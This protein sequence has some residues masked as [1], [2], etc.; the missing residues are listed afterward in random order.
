MTQVRRNLMTTFGWMRVAASM[1]AA[2][3]A[4]CG[5]DDGADAAADWDGLE[6]ALVA[7][8]P[9]GPTGGVRTHGGGR[10]SADK[11]DRGGACPAPPPGASPD[12]I[13]AKPDTRG[14][15]ACERLPDP[16]QRKACRGRHHGRP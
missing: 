1:V 7:P 12:P 5:S 15:D 3:V 13:P 9:I 11:G 8:A 6:A 16:A 10:P 2:V 4:G 14:C